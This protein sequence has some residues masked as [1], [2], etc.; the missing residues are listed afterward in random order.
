MT[1]HTPPDLIDPMI[2]D[3]DRLPHGEALKIDLLAAEIEHLKAAW[4]KGRSGWSFTA[5]RLVRCADGSPPP[6]YDVVLAFHRPRTSEELEKQGVE[7]KAFEIQ[8]D[9][10]YRRRAEDQ[11]DLV[12][13]VL[14]SLE[15]K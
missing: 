13:E 12:Q 14:A 3:S 11:K 10:D 1:F 8:R 5:T 6:A 7:R 2:R 15:K 9:E 4:L